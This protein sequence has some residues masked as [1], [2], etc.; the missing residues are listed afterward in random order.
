VEEVGTTRL[1]GVVCRIFTDGVTVVE[2]WSRG[3]GTNRTDVVVCGIKLIGD[4][5]V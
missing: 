5:G 1:D 2:G 4:C 3:V